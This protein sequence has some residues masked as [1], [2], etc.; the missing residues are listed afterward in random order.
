MSAPANATPVY[1]EADFVIQ[2][3]KCICPHCHSPRGLGPGG[4]ANILK[5]HVLTAACKQ[6]R[7]KHDASLSQHGIQGFLKRQG[8]KVASTV[9]PPLPLPQG[10]STVIMNAARNAAA[11]LPDSSSQCVSILPEPI[12]PKFLQ[13]LAALTARLPDTVPEATSSDA[14]ADFCALPEG[15]E[16][17]D[18]LWE[19]TVNRMLHRVFQGTSFE[20]IQTIIR[21]G[22]KGMDGFIRFV[23]HATGVRGIPEM[24]F[25]QQVDI[26]TRAIMSQIRHETIRIDIDSSETLNLPWNVQ[27]LSGGNQMRF[28]HPCRDL[29]VDG[30]LPG[31]L[32]RFEEGV[33][34]NTP[35]A[36]L[37]TAALIEIA[38]RKDEHITNMRFR[39]LNTAKK[40]QNVVASMEMW[41]RLVVSISSG[42]VK[43][44]DLLLKA[45]A[46]VYKPRNNSEEAMMQG[47]LLWRL[48]GVRVA[49]LG[50]RALGLPGMSTL[51]ANT[52]MPAMVACHTTPALAEILQNIEACLSSG[53]REILAS[54]SESIHLILMLDE[55]ATEKRLRWD[56]KTNKFL[57]ICREHGMLV[58]LEYESE[59]DLDIVVE[60]LESEDIHYASEATVAAM[61]ILSANKRVYSARPM[62]ISGTCKREKGPEHAVLLSMLIVALN[63]KMAAEKFNHRIVSI[64]SDEETR[65]GSALTLLTLKHPLPPSSP[66]YSLLRVL[67]FLNLLVGGGDLAADRDFRHIFK[68]LLNLLLRL[69]GITIFGQLITPTLIQ[70]H[71]KD[72]GHTDLH[73]GAL[74]Y[75]DDKQD[76]NLAYQL[77]SAIWKLP[78]STSTKPGYK[79]ARDALRT[80]GKFMRYLVFPYI[81]IDLSLAEQL[82]SLSAAAF[83]GLFLYRDAQKHFLPTLLYSDIMIMIKNVFFCFAKS[84]VDNPT[85]VFLII[86]LGTDRLE[87][88][89]GIICSMIG[90]DSGCDIL[91][92]A[93]RLTGTTEVGNILAMCQHWDRTPRRLRLP[94]LDREERARVLEGN[95][96]HTSPASWRGD[97][98]I[99]TV[100]AQTCWLKGLSL[101][102]ADTE[103]GA[104][105]SQCYDSAFEHR[106]TATIDILSPLGRY[107]LAETHPSASDTDDNENDSDALPHPS[108]STRGSASIVPK[109]P[110]NRIRGAGFSQEIEDIAAEEDNDISKGETIS[111]RAAKVEQRVMFRG[112]IMN[113]SRNIAL[114]F[115]FQNKQNS[116]DRLKRVEGAPRFQSSVTTSNSAPVDTETP[117]LFIN[118]LIAS[119]VRCQDHLFLCLGEV[120]DIR[121][122]S[123]AFTFIPTETLTE[124]SV[125]IIFQVLFL[126]RA[127][128]DDDPTK[129]NDWRTRR[130]IQPEQITV[131]GRLIQPLNPPTWVDDKHNSYY[132]LESNTLCAV[133]CGF[134]NVLSMAD[135][136]SIYSIKRSTSF[137]YRSESGS[138]CFAIQAEADHELPVH[139]TCPVCSPPFAITSSQPFNVLA[140][141]GGHILFDTDDRSTEPCGTCL[142]PWPHCRWT[143][144]PKGKDA[145]KKIQ[146]L[147]VE[148]CR[149]P[150]MFKYGPASLYKESSPCTNV[151]MRCPKCLPT[152]P[153]VWKYNMPWHFLRAHPGVDI[154]TV[155]FNLK[156]ELSTAEVTVLKQKWNNRG[157]IIKKRPGKGKEDSTN[158]TTDS[159]KAHAAQIAREVQL[160][161]DVEEME[162]DPED[163]DEDFD[164]MDVDSGPAPPRSNYDSDDDPEFQKISS[165][166]DEIISRLGLLTSFPGSL[167]E[168]GP[169]NSIESST[170]DLLTQNVLP[171]IQVPESP[172]IPSTTEIPSASN[173]VA[174]SSRRL[175]RARLK[176]VHDEVDNYTCDCGEPVT[177]L[178]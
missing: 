99:A 174:E 85:G 120:L 29:V 28:C 89:F 60:K 119:V 177:G 80:L 172:V 132:L 54:F 96:D 127:T 101:L 121:V 97:I 56:S 84:K 20:G 36:Y 57:G 162:S 115:K 163:S 142:L 107:L 93:M 157:E 133:A 11:S 143:I 94:S 144:G 173:S 49:E 18:E 81:C 35:L 138:A 9:T 16:T 10:L 126:V 7:A 128:E 98:K 131:A 90:N 5:R 91:Q 32:Q 106:N 130:D 41:K 102:R 71:L 149:N 103:I 146:I 40:L 77:M 34:E 43:N 110:T 75:P 42:E 137:P 22:E 64:A 23:A 66:I 104:K 156:W 151:P 46:G 113:K 169:L 139:D 82:Q 1:T 13:K 141:M 19:E 117:L 105:V 61:G 51:R 53:L 4:V 164:K 72:A 92:L 3:N 95:A 12:L 73:I 8:P 123:Q 176:R 26:L 24:L 58:N 39:N 114:R 154:N 136:K 147:K 108:S 48:G 79:A 76:V 87:A 17:G 70:M 83:L 111:D 166:G 155:K 135:A 86:L 14:L 118:D 15:P 116:L 171:E 68:R 125:S 152:D 30:F 165:E 33:H 2:G 52:R 158:I 78:E 21:R 112:K 65:R 150:M 27:V 100:N 38:R 168:L 175:Q 109:E 167:T 178:E 145:K 44:V 55:I 45:A 50:H 74:L 170:Q 148:G 67:I 122:N 69:R 153:A 47:I 62:M 59:A 31:I 129:K 63:Q 124:K 25:H 37:G 6:E 160:V 161:A 88:L 134:L 140:H 159:A